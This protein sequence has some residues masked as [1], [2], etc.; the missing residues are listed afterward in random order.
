MK[1]RGNTP[2]LNSTSTVHETMQPG[3]FVAIK[4]HNATVYIPPQVVNTTD[5]LIGKK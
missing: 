5:C 4:W 1:R 3:A 2:L